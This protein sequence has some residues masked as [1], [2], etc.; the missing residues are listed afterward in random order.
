MN[1]KLRMLAALVLLPLATACSVKSPD[2][3][4]A[5]DV[6]V[7]HELSLGESQTVTDLKDL[8]NEIFGREPTEG[9]TS[10]WADLLDA[11]KMTLAQV[12]NQL[13]KIKDLM[14]LGEEDST[15]P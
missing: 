8:Y 15:T 4:V 1:K 7:Q 6:K 11:G 13:V 9:E 10:Y 12:K 2:V 14:G 5:G 3:N